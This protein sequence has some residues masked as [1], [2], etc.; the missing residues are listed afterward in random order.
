MPVIKYWFC[1]AATLFSFSLE[2]QVAAPANKIA[3]N[4]LNPTEIHAK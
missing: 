2:R 1:A 3:E 4:K